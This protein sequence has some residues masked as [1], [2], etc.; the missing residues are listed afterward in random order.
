M[1]TEYIHWEDY[2]TG[3]YKKVYDAMQLA[4]SQMIKANGGDAR[5]LIEVTCNIYYASCCLLKFYL[6]N[7]GFFSTTNREVLKHA[8]YI[9]FITDGDEWIEMG[10]LIYSREPVDIRYVV[11]FI[12]ENFSIFEK[13]NNKFKE[14]LAK[15]E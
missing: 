2:Y 13:L 8:F 11:N 14:M 9:N 10:D 15:N 12:I 6:I 5:M 7:N 1:K 3:E 4:Y